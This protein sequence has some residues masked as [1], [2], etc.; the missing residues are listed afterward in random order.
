MLYIATSV[1]KNAVSM[2]IE[3]FRHL[4]TKLFCK[5]HIN[6]FQPIQNLREISRQEPKF[7]F[8]N[9]QGFKSLFWKSLNM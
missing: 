8:S 6:I 5:I 9:L 4:E 7:L 1:A 3:E 2:L